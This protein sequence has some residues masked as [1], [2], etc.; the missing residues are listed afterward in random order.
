MSFLNNGLQLLIPIGLCLFYGCSQVEKSDGPL[1]LLALEEPSNDRDWEPAQ[2]TLCQASFHEDETV[3]LHNVRNCL[4][5][6]EGNLYVLDHYDKTYDLRK[7]TTVDFFLVPFPEMPSMAHTFISFGFEDGEYVAVSVEVRKEKG[8][9]YNPLHG[10]VG[11][12]ELIYV[13]GDEKDIVRWRTNELK[14]DVYMYRI[15]AEQE[16]VYSLFVDVMERA[17]ELAEKPEYYHT[18]KNNC[19]TNLLEHVNRLYPGRIPYTLEVL[20]PGYSDR[21]LYELGLIR[22]DEPFADV[23]SAAYVTGRAQYYADSPDFSQK[24]RE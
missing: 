19:T 2:G 3:T 1:D 16:A 13:I 21:L 11:Q 14:N 8:E 10:M 17:N 20:M 18:I 7:L 6:D 15:Q 5:L 9:N 24:I 12:Y 22:H 23:K 4:H